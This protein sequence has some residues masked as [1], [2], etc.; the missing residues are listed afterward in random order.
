MAVNVLLGFAFLFLWHVIGAFVMASIDTKDRRLLRWYQR[1]PKGG[2]GILPAMFLTLWPVMIVL[3][4][5]EGWF[6]KDG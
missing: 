5:R 2:F 6:R 1:S 4:W 3:L